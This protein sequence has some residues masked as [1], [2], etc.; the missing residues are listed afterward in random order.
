LIAPPLIV[1][2]YV[3]ITLSAIIRVAGPAF[4]NFY[5]YSIAVSGLL[6]IGAFSLFLVVYTPI[7]IGPRADGKPG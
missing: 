3:L 2:A 6:W 1:V 4:P 5:L 7:L